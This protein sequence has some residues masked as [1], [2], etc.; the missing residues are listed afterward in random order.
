MKIANPHGIKIG[1]DPEVFVRGKR[2][3]KFF[4]AHGMVPGDKKE[5]FKVA[6]GAIQ[7]DG[8][9][10]E[11][12]IDPAQDEEVFVNNVSSVF[13]NL[14]RRIPKTMEL[15]VT[16]TAHFP[17]AYMAKQPVE[18]LILGCEPDYNAYTGKANV[19]PDANKPMRTASGHLHFGWTEGADITN[20]L[21]QADCRELAK[22]LDYVLGYWSLKW[23]P[24]KERR[25][26]YG[27]AGAIRYKPYGVEYRTLS[28]AWLRDKRLMAWVFNASLLA[29]NKLKDEISLEKNFKQ[30]GWAEFGRNIIDGT[31]VWMADDRIVQ[32]ELGPEFELPPNLEEYEA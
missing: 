12:N 24:D 22:Q 32:R 5:P 29:V 17:A 20:P 19:R 10:L 13:R 4:N 2:T 14:G 8:M 6:H 7:V 11:F 1:C 25:Q 23:D 28:N 18:S 9:A 3:K 30:I 27:K 21:H 26:M 15:A 31:G 16:P